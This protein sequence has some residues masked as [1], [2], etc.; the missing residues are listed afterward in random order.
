MNSSDG[1]TGWIDQELSLND[2]VALV[3]ADLAALSQAKLA[4]FLL[5]LRKSKSIPIAGRVE[6]L[7]LAE[8]ARRRTTSS[9]ADF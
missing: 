5:S 6:S 3:A 9:R 8:L 7:V 4:Q 1:Q 2:A